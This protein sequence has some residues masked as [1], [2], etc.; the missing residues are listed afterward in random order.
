MRRSSPSPIGLASLAAALLLA[1]CG[2]APAPRDGGAPPG[3]LMVLNKTAARATVVEPDTGAVVARIDVGAGPHEAACS[4]DGRHVVVADYGERTPGHTLTVIDA[5][6]LRVVRTIDLAPYHRPHGLA[7]LD[8]GRL[9]VTAETEKKLLVVQP[10]SGV[11]ERAIDTG[12]QVS[13][14]VVVPPGS[15]RAWVANIGSGSASVL[16][17]DAGTL[18]GV[19]ATGAGAEGIAAHPTRSEVWVTNRAADTVS[20]VDAATREVLAQIPCTGFPIRVAFTLDGA[21]ALV[22]CATAHELAVF[23][24]ESR[25]LE[26]RH[27]MLGPQ[28]PGSPS[29]NDQ[30]APVG[31]LVSPVGDVAFVANTGSARIAVIDLRA[32]RVVRW[33]DAGP[34]P[35]GMA[36]IPTAP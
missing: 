7:F 27:S 28:G 9:L 30:P 11:V 14:M 10:L 19:V 31:V 17:V 25:S 18:E 2:A 6:S 24:V 1:A 36:W 26:R 32:G 13:H 29:L 4:P 12:Q 5:A 23:D 34:H 35:D 33:I 21:K 20:V 22:S 16:D 15:R 8:D 3:L